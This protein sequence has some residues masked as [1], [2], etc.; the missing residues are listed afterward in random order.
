M[1]LMSGDEANVRSQDK[2]GSGTVITADDRTLR[3]LR[4]SLCCRL[5]QADECGL[6]IFM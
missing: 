3:M 2:P 5:S 6:K 1:K 4:L